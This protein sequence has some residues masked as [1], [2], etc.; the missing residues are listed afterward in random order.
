MLEGLDQAPW[1][2][3]AQPEGNF[4]GDVANALRALA[5]TRALD[6]LRA[7]HRVLFALGN[8]H[9]GTYFPVVVPAI[10]F[11][12]EILT[13]EHVAPRLRALDV[14]IDLVASFEPEEG[15]ESIGTATGARP[16]RAVLKEAV[17]ALSS[18]I[19]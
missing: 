14:L 18:D 8:N 12:G 2:E 7:Y 16:L 19:E 4:P 5:A 15:H 3:Y 17:L 9:A 6:D 11:L 10:P 13:S 1:G